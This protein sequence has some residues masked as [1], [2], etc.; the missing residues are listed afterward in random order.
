MNK[1]V[2]FLV[3]I[4]IL[5]IFSG[6]I[7]EKKER[8]SEEEYSEVLKNWDTFITSMN[9]IVMNDLLVPI[10]EERDGWE[11][12]WLDVNPFKK[13]EGKKC[14]CNSTLDIIRHNLKMHTIES[15][16]FKNTTLEPYKNKGEI[17]VHWS[18]KIILS[19]I[20]LEC[21]YHCHQDVNENMYLL[22]Y[23][24]NS[25]YELYHVDMLEL[26]QIIGFSIYKNGEFF[27][28]QNEKMTEVIKERKARYILR[29]LGR[30][31]CYFIDF[32]DWI[33]QYKVQ[34]TNLTEEEIGDSVSEECRLE[35]KLIYPESINDIQYN[36]KSVYFMMNDEDINI[37][38]KKIQEQRIVKKYYPNHKINVSCYVSYTITLPY[39]GYYP[40]KLKIYA[41][42]IEYPKK[43]K[44]TI[45]DETYIVEILP[46][47]N[48]KVI[49]H[50]A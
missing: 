43:A 5:S 23:D 12:Y 50:E 47:G 2:C 11:F 18:K 21:Y 33:E 10:P 28:I 15:G 34:C 7:S 40:H 39:H 45:D 6:C 26:A 3:A 17:E 14:S 46:N 25:T 44:L 13:A 35:L 19:G 1:K 9:S 4:L 36:G 32:W 24:T 38:E 37:M 48:L 31:E 42:F 22:L 20:S 41:T 16:S 30:G 49:D 27:P 8:I 29:H